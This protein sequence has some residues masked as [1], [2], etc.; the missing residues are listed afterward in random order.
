MSSLITEMEKHKK[1]E[2]DMKLELTK[3]NIIKGIVLFA[4]PIYI[5]Q[6]FSMLYGV[7]DTRIVGSVLGESSLASVSATSSLSELIIEFENGVSCGFGIILAQLIGAKNTERLKKTVAISA[8]LITALSVL[9]SLFCI[10]FINPILKYMNVESEIEA[11]AKEYIIIILIGTVFLAIYNLLVAVLRSMGDSATPLAFLIV[12]NV[13]NIILDIAFVKHMKFGVA[14]AAWATVVTQIVCCVG[15]SI[16]LIKTKKELVIK[17]K[18]LVFEKELTVSLCKN[19]MSM[20]CMLSFVLLGSLVLQTAINELGTDIIVA[21]TAARR[22]T[23]LCLIPFFSIGAAMSTY[24]GQ[25]KGANQ[26]ERIKKGVTDSILISAVWWV[27]S[28]A[29]VFLFSS[30]MI[31]AITASESGTIIA[32]AVKYLHVNSILFILPAVICILRNSLQGLGDTR[33]PLISSLIELFGKV[34]ITYTLVA[35]LGY[36]GVI[37]AEPIVWTLMAIPLILKWRTEYNNGYVC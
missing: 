12:S 9:I 7:I 26:P 19:G 33:T 23:I 32:N 28:V 31:T 17:L 13:M 6:L 4:L 29:A 16:Y 25:N 15:C 3:G 34:L 5:G 10:L 11:A 8:C 37:I 30:K 36:F 1:R 21:H 2:N 27:I 24:C 35:P 18:D 14:G 20:G 22:V